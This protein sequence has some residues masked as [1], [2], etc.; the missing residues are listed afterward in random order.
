MLIK[1]KI[2]TG[3]HLFSPHL[4]LLGRHCHLWFL[5]DCA[6]PLVPAL[7]P[8]LLRAAVQGASPRAEAPLPSTLTLTGRPQGPRA[9]RRDPGRALGPQHGGPACHQLSAHQCPLQKSTSAKPP[10]MGSA[11]RRAEKLPASSAAYWATWH[12][13]PFTQLAAAERKRRPF[14]E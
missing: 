4:V 11:A 8:T 12:R 13:A 7:H 1:F 9:C 3:L 5:H 2:N 14:P 6:S 10:V